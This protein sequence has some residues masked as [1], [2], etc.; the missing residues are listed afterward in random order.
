MTY[1]WFNPSHRH[2]CVHVEL[3]ILKAAV[4]PCPSSFFIICHVNAELDF[5]ML[6]P[7]VY[8]IDVDKQTPKPF[9]SHEGQ[10]AKMFIQRTPRQEG[11]KA[12]HMK[13]HV[14]TAH[15]KNSVSRGCD[16]HG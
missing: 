14:S 8:W 7:H 1:N 9:H 3:D 6:F 5:K 11:N 15:R 13:Q 10:S 4:S 2:Q 12:S 16:L